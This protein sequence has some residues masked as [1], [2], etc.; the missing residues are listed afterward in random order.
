MPVLKD[1]LG[2][3]A[4]SMKDKEALVRKSIFPPPPRSDLRQLRIPI[5]VAHQKITQN[6]VY[7]TLVAQSIK[8]TP[9]PNKINF[10]I[11]Y[12]VWS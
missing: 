6:Q 8:K 4:I 9:G 2:N 3:I 7:C 11:L 5:G 12:I 10:G 1:Y